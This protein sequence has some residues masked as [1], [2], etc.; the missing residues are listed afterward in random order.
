[1]LVGLVKQIIKII[2]I[3]V[4]LKGQKNNNHKTDRSGSG[5]ANNKNNNMSGSSNANTIFY[6]FNQ[7]RKCYIMV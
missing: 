4:G 1:M 2:T 6:F 5:K 3:W 7:N